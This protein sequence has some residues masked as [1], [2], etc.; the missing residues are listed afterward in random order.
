MLS[1]PSLAEKEL[2]WKAEKNLNNM[3]E[4]FWRWQVVGLSQLKKEC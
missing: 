2:G 4:D 3:C 1:D